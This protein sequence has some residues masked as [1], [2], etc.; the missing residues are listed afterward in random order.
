M[1]T[2]ALRPGE[3]YEAPTVPLK[4][5]AELREENNRLLGMVVEC[6]AALE[7]ANDLLKMEGFHQGSPTRQT[8]ARALSIAKGTAKPVNK[9]RDVLNAEAASY[10]NQTLAQFI[11]SHPELMKQP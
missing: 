7:M 1:E 9:L 8:I 10:P 11:E 6:V 3:V 2:I 4:T 5:F